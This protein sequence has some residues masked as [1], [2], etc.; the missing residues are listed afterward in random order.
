MKSARAEIDPVVVS[1]DGRTITV[2]VPL[3]LVS[4]GGRKIILTPD[5]APAWVPRYKAVDD[6]LIHALARGHRWRLMLERGDYDSANAIADA[7][8]LSSSFVSRLLRLT[9]L[10]PDLV[11]AIL[12]GRH[13]TSMQAEVLKGAIPHCW[14]EQRAKFA[15]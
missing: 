6:R 15:A 10:A 8:G 12:D 3:Q 11:E 7:E 2:T 9:L 14:A 1:E 4:R 5:K 13:S